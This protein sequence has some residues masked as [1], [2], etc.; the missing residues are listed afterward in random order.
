MN[1]KSFIKT[2]L[3][4]V[5]LLV[6]ASCSTDTTWEEFSYGQ[7]VPSYSNGELPA[8]V[9]VYK[10]RA[11]VKL[12]KDLT[13]YIYLDDVLIKEVKQYSNEKNITLRA[14]TPNTEYHLFITALEGEKVLTKDMT[15]TTHKSYASV[16]GWREMDLYGNNEEEVEFVRQMPGGDFI[17]YTHRYYYYSDDDLRLRRTDADGNVK[18][19]SNIA[20]SHASVSE[21]G[22]IAAWSYDMA[23][24]VNPENG[25]VVYKYTPKSKDGYIH[26]AYACKD[27]GMVVVG[28]GKSVG[29]YYFARIDS[30]G[31]QIH[32]EE[33]DIADELYD[34]H[35]MT[36]GNIVAMGKKGSETFV[37]ITFD[38]SGKVVG[39]SSDYSENRDLSYISYFRQSIRDRNGNTY[40][41]GHY[42][43]IDGAYCQAA[44]LVKT[45]AQGKIVWTRTLHDKYDS[46][47][48]TYMHFIDDDKLC[49]LYY[50]KNTRVAF[51][52]PKNELLRDV[53]FNANYNA[54]YLWP[55]N[56]QYTQFNLFDTYGRIIHIDTEGE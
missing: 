39:K 3:L 11:E 25:A 20:I 22:N 38:A 12:Y 52:T 34:V 1:M 8:M 16:I 40:F 18:W 54:I 2:S 31:Q 15:F 23:C 48:S 49:V 51:I 6:M 43:M 53:T 9:T 30:N 7:E 4:V 28:R 21:E 32:E 36:D 19:R 26:G 17:D 37:T 55:V 47:Y 45:D 33:G 27:G 13:Y 10:D 42:E 46:F 5:G 50:G 35:E 24:R 14:L 41:L 56:D 44:I 29:K